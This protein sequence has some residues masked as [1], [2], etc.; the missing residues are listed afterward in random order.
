ML[1]VKTVIIDSAPIW[2]NGKLDGPTTFM[3]KNELFA[4]ALFLLPVFCFSGRREKAWP[5]WMGPKHSR[6]ICGGAAPRPTQQGTRNERM[7]EIHREPQVTHIKGRV[8]EREKSW[9]PR[10]LQF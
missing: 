6:R 1:N 2:L 4:T 9:Q 7:A 5:G 8:Q 3:V 10:T